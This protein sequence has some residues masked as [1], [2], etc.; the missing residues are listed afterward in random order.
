MGTTEPVK[1]EATQKRKGWLE[2]VPP[3]M[4]KFAAVVPI[5]WFLLW[6][7]AMA[8]FLGTIQPDTFKEFAIEVLKWGSGI[9]AVGNMFERGSAAVAQVKASK[10]PP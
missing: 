5:M 3:G 2:R 9:F 1:S 4:R 6:I 10:D 8:L 7:A